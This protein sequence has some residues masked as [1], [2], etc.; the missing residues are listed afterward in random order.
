MS[1]GLRFPVHSLAPWLSGDGGGTARLGDAGDEG[2]I[3]LLI[4]K[5]LKSIRLFSPLPF[6]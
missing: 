3:R 4:T 1:F 6:Q 5:G 2:D